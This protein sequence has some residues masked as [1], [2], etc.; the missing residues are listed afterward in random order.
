MQRLD[1][2]SKIEMGFPNDFVAKPD[3]LKLIW[4][5]TYE[6]LD[7]ALGIASTRRDDEKIL[8]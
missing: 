4:G 2:V 5:T 1:T 3:I 6:R 8:A 7:P